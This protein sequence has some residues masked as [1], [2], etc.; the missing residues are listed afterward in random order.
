M[1]YERGSDAPEGRQCV[2]GATMPRRGKSGI[3]HN[4]A[5]AC[6]RRLWAIGARRVDKE[7]AISGRWAC[8]ERAT[9][10]SSE[11]SSSAISSIFCAQSLIFVY[12][13]SRV[14]HSCALLSTHCCQ[15]FQF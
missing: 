12:E 13:K 3:A 8:N 7:R 11:K 1:V 4:K 10:I 9:R 14:K 15:V 5:A 6:G 2:G